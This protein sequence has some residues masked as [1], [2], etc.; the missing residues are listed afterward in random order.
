MFSKI[1]NNKKILGAFWMSLAAILFGMMGVSVK[2]SAPYYEAIELVFFRGIFGLIFLGSI[3]V[4]K[5]QSL[6]SQYFILHL[7]RSLVGYFALLLYF[8]S[9][10]QLPL[11]TAVTLNYTSP[12]FLGFISAFYLKE[13]INLL[14]WTAL[15]LG[16]IAIILILKPSVSENTL[17]A[18]LAGLC[19]GVF[20]AL[21][22]LHVKELGRLGEPESRIVFYFCLISTLGGFIW[23]LY[24]NKPFFPNLNR[25]PYLILLGLSATLAQLSMTRAYKV[26]DK[27]VV[28]S[29]SYSTILFSAL[30][31]HLLWAEILGVE[32]YIAM[33]LM[34]IS[35]MLS[36]RAQ[37]N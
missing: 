22:Y 5:K 23:F 34:I 18:V 16:F 35:G 1:K 31:A 30:F 6:K 37:N 11:G 19:S 28:A 2:Y 33:S 14:N 36:I 8:Y 26:G 3:I 12:L 20:A 13:K 10:T 24:V 9:M 4:I 21:A 32:I 15:I 25:L 7:K 17:F 29:V 27:F